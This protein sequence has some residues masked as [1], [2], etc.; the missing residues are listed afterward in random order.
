MMQQDKNPKV[1][2]HEEPGQHRIVI[3][4]PIT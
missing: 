2:T 3:F 1:K 4:S